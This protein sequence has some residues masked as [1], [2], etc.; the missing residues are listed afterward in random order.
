MSK[1]DGPL[2]SVSYAGGCESSVAF[3]SWFWFWFWE[4]AIIT[5]QT[6]VVEKVRRREGKG[7][8]RA[9]ERLGFLSAS[10]AAAATFPA[11]LHCSHTDSE[12]EVPA[13]KA[14]VE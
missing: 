7:S 2:L 10:C 1:E 9:E 12:P 13:G 8:R 6:V 3:A 14:Y 11:Q 5:T 4:S